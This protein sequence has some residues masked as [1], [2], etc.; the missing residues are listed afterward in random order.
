MVRS[1]LRQWHSQE[2]SGE[3]ATFV[4]SSTRESK[5][6][7]AAAAFAAAIPS[8]LNAKGDSIKRTAIFLP[9]KHDGAVMNKSCERPF[10]SSLL[11]KFFLEEVGRKNNLWV[12]GV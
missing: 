5:A 4:E 7:A 1:I 10:S 9:T 12:S 8:R 3:S 6:H 2:A 11:G